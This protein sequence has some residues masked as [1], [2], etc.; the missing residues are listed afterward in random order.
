MVE[1]VHL[2]SDIKYFILVAIRIMKLFERRSSWWIKDVAVVINSR[3]RFT[4]YFT[5]SNGVGYRRS[6][7]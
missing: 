2:T 6:I 1:N 7:R 5:T 4:S 3:S